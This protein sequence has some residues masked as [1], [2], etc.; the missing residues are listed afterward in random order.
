MHWRE[1]YPDC[2]KLNQSPIN[3]PPPSDLIF[4]PSVKDLEF[5]GFNTPEVYK[6]ELL[7]NGHT[8]IA[9]VF[10]DSIFVSG[11]GLS[12]GHVFKT[13]QFHFHWAE[14]SNSGS[15]HLVT[16]KSY[17]L[18][19]HIVSFN[20]KY[21]SLY[22]AVDKKDGLAVIAVFFEATE[23]DNYKLIPLTEALGKITNTGEKCAIDN[24]AFASL[25]PQNRSCFYRYTGSLTTPGC[26]ESVTWTIFSQTIAIS[27]Q[28]LNIFRSLNQQG[29]RKIGFNDRPV[30]DLHG[31]R[32]YTTCLLP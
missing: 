17:P 19:A 5:E 28:Q 25:L 13:E 6:L 31:R 14:D 11:A 23:E 7:N 16:G 27:E 2:G 20:T 4:D 26:Y 10:S 21:Q 18:E 8:A 12:N 22:E 1:E 24:F 32:V 3:I 30:Q 15:E 29:N 9:K